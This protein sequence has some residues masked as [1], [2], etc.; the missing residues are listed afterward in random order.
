MYR[1]LVLVI[2]NI[3]SAIT[4]FS[5]ITD[6]LKFRQKLFKTS[7]SSIIYKF[8][9]CS[10]IWIEHNVADVEVVGSSPA[11]GAKG[12]VTKW[13]YGTAFEKRRGRNVTV[14]SNP[15]PTAALTF[16]LCAC[17]FMYIIPHCFI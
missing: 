3:C 10:L 7:P 4:V 5:E 17:G 6:G 9:P 13:L 11:K 8:S 15:T 1:R 14:G 12:G 16:Y 2:P